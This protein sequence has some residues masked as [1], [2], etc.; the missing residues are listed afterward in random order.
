MNDAVR[1][2]LCELI[3][4]YERSLV[5]DVRR[6]ESL[7][8]DFCGATMECKILLLA[9]KEQVPQELLAHSP[10]S[11]P[12]VLARLSQKLEQGFAM[13][14]VA[15]KWAVES[16]AIA[17]G[18]VS[19]TKKS[20]RNPKQRSGE[21]APP[22]V[23]TVQRT[24]VKPPLMI[25]KT[26]RIAT[27]APQN[28]EITSA[29]T[30]MKLTLIPA[31]EFMMGSPGSEIWRNPDEGPQHR[32]KISRPFYMGVYEV[33]QDEF[34]QIMGFNPSS[35]SDRGKRRF[36]VAN[37]ETSRFPVDSVSWFDAL[38][39]CNKLSEKDGLQ[40][41]YVLT[42]AQRRNGSIG[43]AEVSLIAGNGYR[44]PTEAEWEYACRG[45]TTTPFH[46]GSELDGRHANVGG[47]YPHAITPKGARLGR[48]TAV[49]SYPTNSFGLH[50]MHGN[51]SEWC[52]DTFG[53]DAYQSRCDTTVDPIVT[54]DSVVR[55]IRGGCW[56]SGSEV[57]RS[58]YRGRRSAGT[59]LLEAGFRIMRF[60]DTTDLESFEKFW[61]D[62][63]VTDSGFDAVAI[64]AIQEESTSF[65]IGDDAVKVICSQCGRAYLA[66]KLE[67]LTCH[68][69]S[70]FYVDEVGKCVEV[71]LPQIQPSGQPS[72]T[73]SDLSSPV[74]P[75]S[76]SRRASVITSASTGMHLT[77][78]PAGEFMMGS[79][80]SE[81]LRRNDEGPQH[82]V[83]ISQPFYMG[84]YQVTQSEFAQ[85]MGSNPSSSSKRNDCPVDTVSWFD[86]VIFCNNLSERDGMSP[87]YEI[88]NVRRINGSIA[89]ADVLTSGGNG[90]RL[91]TE[92]E[93]EYACRGS[94]TTPFH[95]GDKL[96][97]SQ[98]NV[99][100]NYPYGTMQKGPRLGRTT[101]VGSYP[102]NSFGLYDMHGNVCEWCWD[103]YVA[104]AYQ[105]C[106]STTTDPLVTE[107]SEFRV[108]RGGS[109]NRNPEFARSAY[110]G[111]LTAS[112]QIIDVGFRVVTWGQLR[113]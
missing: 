17:L 23:A 36:E 4:H 55:V 111:R 62:E 105:S 58:A 51:V 92:A 45:N 43:Y 50:D 57:A 24:G 76:S 103:A 27:G 37:H 13:E 89:F 19:D 80:D 63:Y 96:N 66:V 42:H 49:G 106:K 82:R 81:F 1:Q 95:F 29:S 101:T 21:H 87:C 11:W 99:D 88:E 109:W 18:I 100:G 44:L 14:P 69:G 71:E 20:N 64:D 22:E 8:R 10:D 107:G 6:C 110:R 3:A 7:M 68:C 77:L 5:D 98:A 34:A 56:D 90:Y 46:F 94:T 9:M 83:K 60:E 48:T 112:L 59:Q 28:S 79:H 74:F 39:F 25:P 47:N 12:L 97:G 84:V 78:I 26:R 113:V 102:K 52:W 65:E 2:R 54:D 61:D 75:T 108:L 38:E 32:V 16:W 91:P 53:E 93:W 33:T 86:A 35:F 73:L 15:A 40:P 31:G 85:I 70:C 104:D 72:P 41:C 30:G 67:F